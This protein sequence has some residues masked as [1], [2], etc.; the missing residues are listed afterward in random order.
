[1]IQAK[2]TFRSGK[3]ESSEFNATAAE[4]GTGVKSGSK[5]ESEDNNQQQPGTSDAADTFFRKFKSSV[6]SVSPKVSLAFQKLKEAKPMDLAKKGYDVVKDELSSN[7]SKRK[8]LEYAVST[9]E[10]S[11]R[12]DVAVVASKQSRL[13]KMW[14]AFKEKAKKVNCYCHISYL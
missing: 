12:T 3:Q 14:E 8:H 1:M 9:G 10:R 7:P 4:D 11:S 13:S 2:D 5:A 6:S